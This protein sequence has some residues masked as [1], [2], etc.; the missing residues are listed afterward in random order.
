MLPQTQISQLNLNYNFIG[1]AG[2]QALAQV[3]PQ[4]QITQLHLGS[5]DI[6][7]AGAQ[8]LAQVLPQTQITQ[9]N[10]RITKS[11]MQ[12]LRP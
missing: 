2:A 9:L 5:N 10:L 12:E 7:D 4:T 3:L 6:G 1:D 11:E 8:A